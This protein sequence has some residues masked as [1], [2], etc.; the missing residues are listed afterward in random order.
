MKLVVV[1]VPHKRDF[2][3][4]TGA[5][6]SLDIVNDVRDLLP[7]RMNPLLHR[8]RAIDE[9]CDLNLHGSPTCSFR[10]K[11]TSIFKPVEIPRLKQKELVQCLLRGLKVAKQN[12]IGFRRAPL[13][14][15]RRLLPD[16]VFLKALL[17]EA[18]HQ[19]LQ[20]DTR[21]L[22]KLHNHVNAS[23]ANQS[24]INLFREVGGQHDDTT[25][26]LQSTIQNVEQERKVNHVFRIFLLTHA[27]SPC[28]LVTR[29]LC[30]L[31]LLPLTAEHEVSHGIN[32]LDHLQTLV[33]RDRV[34]LRVASPLLN[35]DL[36]IEEEVLKLSLGLDFGELDINDVST[37][38]VGNRLGRRSLTT[39]R[40]SVKQESHGL[41]NALLLLPTTLIQ[42]E[43]DTLLN[44]VALGKEHVLKRPSGGKFGL[45]VDK[46][47]SGQGVLNLVCLGANHLIKLVEVASQFVGNTTRL[48]HIA[49]VN[50]LLEVLDFVLVTEEPE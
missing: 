34:D 11:R 18:T 4:R 26:A 13:A 44:R 22:L 35:M 21:T 40:I 41:W 29:G 27:L 10:K 37:T 8:V 36:L 6:R 30:G 46:M 33:N 49:G 45:G 23:R 1:R 25:T 48:V 20:N 5:L 32:V 14:V 50:E 3:R 17:L 9:E 31:G 28:I 42:E 43:V 19:L 16:G 38:H 7:N 2:V 39:P 24:P 15:H 12:L 47:S